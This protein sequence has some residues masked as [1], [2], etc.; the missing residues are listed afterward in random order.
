M[1]EPTGIINK[2]AGSMKR[3]TDVLLG[4]AII[5]ATAAAVHEVTYLGTVT[6]VTEGRIEVMV[7]D[8]RAGTESPMT[9]AVSEETEIF[10]GDHR[11]TLAD[12]AFEV[13]ERIAV[14]INRE[15]AGDRALT[16]RLA[17]HH[18]E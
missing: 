16:I 18:E 5:V 9:F 17:D 1:F 14:T 12:A 4:A 8:E 15:V 6:A 3:I 2:E 13:G 11:M 7:V 10:R